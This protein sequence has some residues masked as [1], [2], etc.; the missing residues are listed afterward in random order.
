M[1]VEISV[2]KAVVLPQSA[3]DEVYEG[4]KEIFRQTMEDPET[5][6][7]FTETGLTFAPLVG[8][9]AYLSIQEYGQF[10]KE[11]FVD[12]GVLDTPLS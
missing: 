6:K 1:D 3:S 2:G 9:E 11:N 8:E 5:E 7:A 10:I 12:N 4:W